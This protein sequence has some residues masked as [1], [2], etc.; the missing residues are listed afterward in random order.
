MSFGQA[1]QVGYLLFCLEHTHL[2]SHE[3]PQLL[4]LF[5]TH[6]HLPDV[7]NRHMPHVNGESCHLIPIVP[8]SS[9][10]SSPSVSAVSR[11]LTGGEIVAIIFGLLLVVALLIGIL[12]VFRSRCRLLPPPCS[13]TLGPCIWSEALI[14][15]PMALP[16]PS[17][18]AQRCPHAHPAHPAPVVSG[19]N[20]AR[21]HWTTLVVLGP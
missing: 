19:V 2:S 4:F 7:G 3:A 13:P 12:H 16:P 5:P 14:I 10:T 21:A 17:S 8:V 11:S 20:S 9:Q 15:A 1:R 6:P 18:K